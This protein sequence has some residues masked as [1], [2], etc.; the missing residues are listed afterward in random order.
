MK[1][2][3]FEACGSSRLELGIPRYEGVR[4]TGQ[5]GAYSIIVASDG[6]RRLFGV[7]RPLEDRMIISEIFCSFVERKLSSA[8]IPRLDPNHGP[9]SFRYHGSVYGCIRV[10][11]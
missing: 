11:V 6:C 1:V 7:V 5:N 3:V 4:A 10:K 8:L 9:F 2:G